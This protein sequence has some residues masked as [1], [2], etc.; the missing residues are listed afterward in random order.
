MG[1][2]KRPREDK[3]ESRSPKK[4]RTTEPEKQKASIPLVDKDGRAAFKVGGER[5]VA[6]PGAPEVETGGS[7]QQQV[8]AR[9]DEL[10]DVGEEQLGVGEE[11]IGLLREA[12]ELLKELKGGIKELNKVLRGSKIGWVAAGDEEGT[13]K[14]D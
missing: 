13:L 2:K 10:V 3:P 11:Q 9:L 14:D 8:C 6:K 5:W 4:A 7:G 1:P 12:V